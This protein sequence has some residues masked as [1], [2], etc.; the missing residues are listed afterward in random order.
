MNLAPQPNR[1]KT[2]CAPRAQ[3]THRDK[4]ACEFHP[5]PKELLRSGKLSFGALVLYSV[6][7]N[8]TGQGRRLCTATDENLAFEICR[9]PSCVRRFLAELEEAGLIGQRFGK[10]Q[11]IRE[12]S[13]S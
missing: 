12:E 10:S 1:V 11:R 6:L 13:R 9:A 3:K 8:L 7:A 2:Q 5:V 4:V